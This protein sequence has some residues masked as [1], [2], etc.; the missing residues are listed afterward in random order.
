MHPLDPRRPLGHPALYRLFSNLIYRRGTWS[1]YV[2]DVLRVRPGQR[3]LDIGCGPADILDLLP[4]VEYHG[5][6][7][8]PAYVASASS[9]FAERGRFYCRR[10]E[11]TAVDDLGE[12][13]LIMATGILHHLTDNEVL[14]LLNLARGG[15]TPGGRF[16][17]CDGCYTQDQHPLARLILRADRGSHVRDEQGYSTLASAVFPTVVATVYDHFLRVPWSCVVLDCSADHNRA[18]PREQR[19][20]R[21]TG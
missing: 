6:D 21:V 8:N 1:W 19:S 13:D 11:A 14:D 18:A 9:R 15:L 16:V 2:R 12:F 5:F 20:A 17:S 4:A 7:M 3:V 10:V